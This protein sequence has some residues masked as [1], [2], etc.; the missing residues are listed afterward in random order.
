M[1][2]SV[3]LRGMGA[4][5]QGPHLVVDVAGTRDE[6]TGVGACGRQFVFIRTIVIACRKISVDARGEFFCF[7]KRG[8]GCV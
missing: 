7:V 2:S 8:V 6:F 1:E 5:G 3:G 4:S